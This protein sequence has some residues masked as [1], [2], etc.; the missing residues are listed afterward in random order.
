MVTSRSL[1]FAALATV[2]LGLAGCAG[3]G[4]SPSP[5]AVANA[6]PDA[7]GVITY[8]SYQ[9]AVGRDGDTIATLAARVGGSADEIARLNGLP[10]DYRLRAG[11]VVVLPDSV[12]RPAP[13]AAAGWTPEQAA[14]AI[15]AAPE[16][17]TSALAPQARVTGPTG[18]AAPPPPAPP[19]ASVDPLIDP[20]RHRVEAGETVYSIARLYGVSVTAL[21]SWNG[22]GPDFTIRENQELLIPIVSGANQISSTPD[23]QPG[24][25]TEVTPPPIATTPLP[26]NIAPGANPASP[27]LGQFRTPA[28]GRLQPPVGGAVARPFDA[29]SPNGVGFA[30]D[31][32]TPVR[33]A[34]AGEVG[35]ISDEIGGAGAIVIIS[36]PDD[37]TTTYSVLQNVT[38]EKGD[39]VEA[40]QIIG[41]VGPRDRQEL[42]FD[43]YRGL[44]PLD[45]TTY[46]PGG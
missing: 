36:H 2:C 4:A 29:A 15:E 42:Q 24:Q 41:T 26:E 17:T 11:E 32:G 37:L 13:I 12:P 10:V 40:G 7:R 44:E 3:G 38:L 19:P 35:L 34:A 6:T 5:S 39:R 25:R 20:V 22:L 43:V 9:V 33:A 16:I 23:T 28:G 30:A 31:V 8:A 27:N 45:P 14:A 21:A 46:L 1:R 18:A